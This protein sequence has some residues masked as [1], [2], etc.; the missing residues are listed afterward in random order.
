M[1]TS[2]KGMTVLDEDGN[3]NIYINDRLS[4]AARMEVYEHEMMHI[5]RNDHYRTASIQEKENINMTVTTP[6][7][8]CEKVGSCITEPEQRLL[9]AEK[10]YKRIRKHLYD[11]IRKHEKKPR[12]RRLTDNEF[13]ALI[14]KN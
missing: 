1:P 2:V 12:K 10:N 4:H 3:Y 7:S 14:G 6:P 8:S 5:Q 11:E 13:L 9:R